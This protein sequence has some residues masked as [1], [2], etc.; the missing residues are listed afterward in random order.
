MYVVRDVFR[1]K[2]GKSRQAAEIFKLALPL[3]QKKG[4]MRNGRIL[5]DMVADY[6][7]VVLEAEVENLAEFERE[8]ELYGKSEEMKKAVQG[9]LDCVEGGRREILR[10]V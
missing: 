9:Y 3:M 7:T 2:P 6:W 8:F 4:G 10:I 5:L 1:C